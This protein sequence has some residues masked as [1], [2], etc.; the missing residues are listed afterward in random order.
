M[1]AACSEGRLWSSSIERL[2]AMMN[3]TAGARV[4][5]GVLLKRSP[6][7]RSRVLSDHRNVYSVFTTVTREM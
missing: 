5:G 1:S 6:P 3:G 4:P 7:R 2:A